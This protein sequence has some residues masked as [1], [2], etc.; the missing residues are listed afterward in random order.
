MEEKHFIGFIALHTENG[1]QRKNLNPGD[2]PEAVF[3]LADG[4]KVIAAYA[5]CNLHSLWK[6]NA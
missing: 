2:A 1:V 3:A 4:D 5:Y 6:V